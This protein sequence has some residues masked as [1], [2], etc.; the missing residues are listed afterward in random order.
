MDSCEERS[1]SGFH[2]RATFV[3]V[4]VNDLP[5]SVQNSSVIQYADDTTMTVAAND[6]ETLERALKEDAE[7]VLSWADRNHL[8]LNVTKTKLMLLGRKKR[9]EE[10]NGMR[11]TMGEQEIQKSR[12]VKCLG[13]VLDDCLTWRE[14]IESIRS[15]LQD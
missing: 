2:P 9:E 10:L 1:T 14:Q 7:K 5:K 4:Y 12:L 3:L 6:V 11:V 15:V 13:V 8:R